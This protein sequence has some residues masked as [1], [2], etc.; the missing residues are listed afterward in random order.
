[1]KEAGDGG[2]DVYFGPTAP[3]GIDPNWISTEGRKPYV[4]L[5]L[6]GPDEAFWSK[7]FKMP[8]PEHVDLGRWRAVT[9]WQSPV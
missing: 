4:W 8:D 7:S 2:V 5:R 1:M 6:Y 3:A 9:M